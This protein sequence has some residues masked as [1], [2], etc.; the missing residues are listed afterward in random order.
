MRKPYRR[1]YKKRTTRPYRRTYRRRYIPN[2]S[3]TQSKKYHFKRWWDGS[4]TGTATS[5]TSDAMPDAITV[6][7]VT[8]VSVG[9]AFALTRVQNYTEFTALFDQYR[10]NCIVILMKL[11]Y[12][13]PET[14]TP[15]DSNYMDVALVTDY[16][17][18]QT[19]GL[20]DMRQYQ[21]YRQ[22]SLTPHRWT[23]IKVWPKTLVGL[24]TTTP[25]VVA[26]SPKKNWIDCSVPGYGHYGL[27]ITASN[28]NAAT[29]QIIEFQYK[30]YLSFKGLR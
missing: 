27:K 23:K 30:F 1:T 28:A 5:N 6:G 20:S 21:S 9:F 29:A 16:D 15:V 22:L 14:E 13:T 12:N 3:R 10:I 11:K 26:T 19:T 4:G 7:A 2:R 18:G 17:D 8:S 25:T 24:A